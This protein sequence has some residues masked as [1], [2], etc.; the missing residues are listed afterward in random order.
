MNSAALLNHL[1]Q[2]TAFAVAATALA[3]TLQR[4]QAKVRFWVWL[5]AS[6]KFLVPF[7]VLAELGAL[8]PGTAP[9]AA[10]PAAWTALSQPFATVS[11]T[12]ALAAA[13]PRSGISWWAI[14]GTAWLLGSIVLAARWFCAW[15][16]LWRLARTVN[17]ERV[18]ASFEP[19]V[20]GIFRPVL[21]LPAVLA[22]ER[23]HI[24]RRDNL[25]SALHQLV[26]VVFWFHPLVWWIGARMV[27]E[28]ERAC[29]EAVLAEGRN[30]AAYAGAV[31]EVCRHFV[32]V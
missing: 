16:G 15:L 31:I 6:L 5:A 11:T 7:G 29:D 17:G 27:A 19:G 24:R 12:V 28:R 32:A 3:W 20:F 4:H 22:H 1:W 18:N 2:S 8:L 30:P 14:L 25:W 21:L 26:E 13:A 10:P 23:C 9:A